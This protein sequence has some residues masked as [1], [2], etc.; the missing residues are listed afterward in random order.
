MNTLTR[1]M[2]TTHRRRVAALVGLVAITIVAGAALLGPARSAL[3]S[4][5]STA[6]ETSAPATRHVPS[7]E[8]TTVTNL[9]HKRIAELAEP[10]PMPTNVPLPTT[11]RTGPVEGPAQS[12]Q[13]TAPS[14]PP[15]PL[16]PAR[17][18]DLP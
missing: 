9:D 12:Y 1:F 3:A 15:P 18:R 17:E 13:G 2:P 7:S 16:P 5:T 4:I 10:V 8:R 11:Q 6:D 14:A